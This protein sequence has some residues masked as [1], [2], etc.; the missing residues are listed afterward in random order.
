[1]S[2]L[3]LALAAL[4]LV[5][6][7]PVVAQ[8]EATTVRVDAVRTEPFAQTV[9]ILGRLVAAQR[10]EVAAR[11]AA[12][13][14]TLAVQVGDRVE[15]GEAVAELDR[16]RLEASAALATARVSAA[17]AQI[18]ADRA[19]LSLLQ[20]ELR[21][22]ARLRESA[23]FSPAQLED[24]RQEIEAATARITR[25][26][27][28]LEEARADLALARTD[29][30]DGVVR[31]PYSGV[32]TER[33]VSAGDYVVPG[34]PVVALLDDDSLEI[35]ADVPS[36][37]VRNLD[38]SDRVAVRFDDGFTTTA[39]LRAIVPD[40]NPRTRTL[41]VRFA[42][43]E[44]EGGTLLASGQSITLEIPVGAARQV[45]TVDKDAVLRRPS[46]DMV[47]V[48][49]EGEAQPRPVTLGAATGERFVVEAGLE[50]GE[51]V[52]VRGN[53]RLRPGQAIAYEA[54]RTAAQDADDANAS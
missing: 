10:G 45:V 13:V 20:Q 24:K 51:L 23:A 44:T 30:D 40:E 50:P 1:M 9:P 15:A 4:A 26:E 16:D 27:A 34:E 35:E 46:G 42:L 19:E 2:R 22:L 3:V 14:E 6:A 32:V 7:S 11:V 36:V 21:R 28:Q 39:R 5:I 48:A 33:Y 31:A 52:V 37:R 43:D 25:A 41:A 8:D 38:P 49:A 17:E 18:A 12:A 53:E 54:P 29:L 47:F